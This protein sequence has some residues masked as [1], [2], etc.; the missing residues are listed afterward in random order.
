MFCHGFCPAVQVFLSK[1][2][3]A[4]MAHSRPASLE[5]RV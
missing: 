2:S 3:V 5:V 4:E 1:I